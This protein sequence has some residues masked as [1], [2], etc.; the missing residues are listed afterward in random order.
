M[1]LTSMQSIRAYNHRKLEK[2]QKPNIL[3]CNLNLCHLFHLKV[4][5]T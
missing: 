3:V 1:G 4:Q 2:S 5:T